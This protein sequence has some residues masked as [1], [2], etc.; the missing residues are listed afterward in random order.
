LLGIDLEEK[1]VFSVGEP[2]TLRM[3]VRA[4][5]EAHYE[6]V[7]GATLVR[8]DGV[9]VSNFIGKSISLDLSEGDTRDLDLRLEG[10]NLG[11][12]TYVFSLSI[13]ESVVALDGSTRY[14]LVARAYEFQVI[15]NDPLMQA[16][17]FRHPGDWTLV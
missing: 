11:N 10:I 4:Y 7:P 1:A 3:T 13:F 8:L 17:I 6:L 2:L 12:G 15:G 9:F 5:R 14:D 16:A